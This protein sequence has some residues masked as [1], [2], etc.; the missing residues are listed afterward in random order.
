MTQLLGPP[1]R[2]A[3]AAASRMAAGLHGEDLAGPASAPLL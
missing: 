1:V 2:R 3:P